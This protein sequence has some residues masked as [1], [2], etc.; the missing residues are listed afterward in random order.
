MHLLIVHQN[1]VDHHH[2]GGT[3]HF[4]LARH[5]VSRGHRCTIVAG[6]VDF[7]TGN[8]LP[9][10]ELVLQGVG[11]RRAYAP[12]TLHHSYLGRAISYACF[13]VTSVW[14]GFRAGPIDAV[15][16]T[17]PPMFQMPSAWIIARLRRRPFVLEIRDL[18]PD[19]AV[20]MG[21]LR[22]R[23]MIA[24][25][26]GI[27]RFFYQH[28][29]WA[30]VNSPGYRD[31]LIARG[32]DPTRLTVIPNGVE[33]SMFQPQER[34][35]ALRARLRLE[36]HFVVTYAGAMGKANDLATLLRAAER[37]RDEPRVR[38]LLVGGGK[39]SGALQQMASERKLDNVVFGGAY[40]KSQIHEIYAASDA[41][42]ASL[43]DLPMFRTTY[44]NKVF[45]Y[46]AAGR[47]VILAIDGVIRD[48]I[49][50]AGP[51]MRHLRTPCGAMRTILC[52]PSSMARPD[53]SM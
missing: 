14:E 27:E 49:Q 43:Q 34:A 2:P 47:P 12:A 30:I 13:M 28:Q 26:R 36:D 22:N 48:V 31:H 40:P 25:A 11:L 52:S 18:W 1:F 4:E 39:E 17:S 8:R 24:L 41:C 46:M 32:A 15:L 5:L 38:F 37:L 10:G 45:D 35:A 51:T 44:P 9:C 16:G 21:V 3:R 19:F 50:D 20:E 7:L 33:T 29:D 42:V 53:V 23:S 6:S